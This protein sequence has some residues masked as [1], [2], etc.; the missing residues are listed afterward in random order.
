VAKCKDFAGGFLPP[1]TAH[2]GLIDAI[3]CAE[4]LLAQRARKGAGG[5]M[6]RR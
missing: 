6:V 4:L 5:D 1:Y 2:D 3:A